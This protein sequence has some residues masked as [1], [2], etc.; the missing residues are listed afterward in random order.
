[1]VSHRLN[2]LLF[3]AAYFGRRVFFPNRSGSGRYRG[4]CGGHRRFDRRYQ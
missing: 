3:R 1:M 2:G 4:P